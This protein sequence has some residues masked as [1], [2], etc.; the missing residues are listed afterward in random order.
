MTD[1]NPTAAS[2]LRAKAEEMRRVAAKLDAEAATLEVSRRFRPICPLSASDTPT[3][4]A[5]VTFTRVLSGKT[6]HYAA[7]GWV[8]RRKGKTQ[9]SMTGA[10]GGRYSWA[11]LLDFIEAE[12]WSSIALVS[13]QVDLMVR[14]MRVPAVGKVRVTWSEAKERLRAEQSVEAVKPGAYCRPQDH[15]V[16]P[17]TGTASAAF[18]A[19]PGLTARYDDHGGLIL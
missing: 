13:H 10:D 2:E 8:D 6:Y 9:W 18:D 12:N 5:V 3:A 16:P 14:D 19:S 1:T 15:R 11:A 17:R 7:L 4:T